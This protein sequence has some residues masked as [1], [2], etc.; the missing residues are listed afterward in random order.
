MKIQ[1]P[2]VLLL[3]TLIAV[4][5]VFGQAGPS[6]VVLG[7]RAVVMVADAVYAFPSAASRVLAVAG[8]DQGLGT[9]LTAVDPAFPKK[10]TLDRNATAESFA[11]L[12][13]DLVILKSAMRGSLGKGLEGLGLKTLYLNLETPEDYYADLAALGAAFSEEAR[14]AELIAY[15][16]DKA[17]DTVRRVAGAGRPRVLLVQAGAGASPTW[18]A[19]PNSWIQTTLVRMAGGEPVWAGAVPGAGWARLGAEQ[20]A[21]W[22]PEVVIVVSYREDSSRA[23]GAF[24]SDPR[25]AALPAVTAGRVVAMPQDYYSWDQPDTRWILG[26]RRIASILH[27]DRFSDLR[28]GAEVREFFR[29]LYALDDRAFDAAILPLLKGAHGAE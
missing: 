19:P 9:F 1:R 22:A 6:R 21:A 5:S 26:L 16:R 28:P 4:A 13:P 11:A 12:K 15:Y 10:P 18:E 2:L 14:A 24:R 8:T 25:F 7:G 20:I 27:P 3:G 23:A 17:E 29:L